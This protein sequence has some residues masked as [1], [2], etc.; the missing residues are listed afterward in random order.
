[1]CEGE[2]ADDLS[3]L[4]ARARAFDRQP[5]AAFSYC[6]RNT[7]RYE[8]LSYGQDGT[9]KKRRTEVVAHGTAFGYRRDGGDTLLLTNDHVAAWPAVTDD[10]HVVE[11]IAAGCKKVSETLKIV[12][13]EA[14]GFDRD[15]I[16][17]ARVVTDPQL[18]VAVLRAH[19][20]LEVM[21]WKVGHSAALRERNVVE[22]RGFPLG[23]F[24]ATNV[25]KV[26]SA[27]DHDDYA[28]WDHDDFV[29]DALLSAGN[30]GSPVLAVSCHTGEFELVGIFHA[31]Y[32]RGS[33]MN[34]VVGIDQVRP[35]MTS[36]KRI[37]R[38]HTEPGL[39]VDGSERG[40]ILAATADVPEIFFP[41]GNQA[42]LARTIPENRLLFE[43]FSTEFPRRSHPVA[44]VEDL[45]S[46]VPTAFGSLGRLWFGG[47]NGLRAYVASDLDAEAQSQIARSLDILRRAASAAVTLADAERA[48]EKS[49]DGSRGLSRFQA[50]LARAAALDRDATQAFAELAARLAP[51]SVD[52]GLPLVTV[53]QI[54]HGHGEDSNPPGSQS[55]PEPTANAV[56]VAPNARGVVPTAGAPTPEGH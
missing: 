44:V 20:A 6:V 4:A 36:L 18:D 10:E 47:A 45:P 39:E 25:G 8:C 54:A 24:R 1:M 56:A 48:S 26:V 46:S 19:G 51:D 14:D 9:V 55:T 41:F 27:Y 3:A 31:G 7:A 33:A 17:L 11:G 29:V 52:E 2:Y 13:D 43:V 49:P 42:A 16:P 50:R 23:A 30:S 34:V 22:V 5:Q 21:P 38:P 12:D 35:L 37:P 53:L 40:K 32:S 15:D 28:E